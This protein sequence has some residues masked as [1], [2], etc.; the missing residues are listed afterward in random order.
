MLYGGC[1]TKKALMNFWV[2]TKQVIFLQINPALLLTLVFLYLF[3]S[4]IAAQS[5]REKNRLKEPGTIIIGDDI[6][7]PP[8]SFVNAQGEPAG[9]N[10][11]IARAV[12]KEMGLNVVIVQDRWELIREALENGEIDAISGLFYTPQRAEIYGFSSRHSV[13][14]G[15]IFINKK[16]S[17]GAL[18]N[19]KGKEVVAQTADVYAEYLLQL[20]LDIKIIEVGTVKEALMLVDKGIYDYAVVLK[21]PGLYSISEN[22]LQHVKPAGI[23][24]LPKD[25]CMAVKKENEDLLYT[26]NLG[27]HILKA[28]EQYKAIHDKWLGVYEQKSFKD[29]LKENNWILILVG[30]IILSLVSISVMLK[31]LVSKRTR[32]LQQVNLNLQ[33]SN[34]EIGLKNLQLAESQSE[35]E[36]QLEKIQKQGDIIRFKQNFLANMSHEI[37]T[38]LTG[39]IGI[40]DILEKT[41]LSTEQADYI[42]MLRLSGENLREIINQVLDYSKIEAGKLKLKKTDFELTELEKH[43]Y[44]IFQSIAKDSISFESTIDPSIPAR[45][46]ADKNRLMQIISNLISNAIKFTAQGKIRFSAQNQTQSTNPDE[47][48]IKISISDT[49][50]GIEERKLKELFKPFAQ[51]HQSDYREYEGTG[52]GLSICSELVHIHGGEIGVDSKYGSGSTFWFTF[53]TEMAPAS[54]PVSQQINNQQLEKLKNLRILLVEDKI[55]NQKVMKLLL[56]SFGHTLELAE[57]GAIALERYQPGKFDMILMDIQ[58]PVMD[59]ITATRKLREMHPEMPPIIG[60]SANAFEG[61]REKYMDMGLDEYLTKPLKKEDFAEVINRI[62][63]AFLPS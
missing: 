53:K 26:L 8:Y 63:P 52:L 9:F 15:D 46:I 30:S 57:N 22:N 20:D 60:L 19:L 2:N 58:M 43:A 38:P 27:L 4:A 41:K 31:F 17:L 59:G 3:P 39:V 1:K 40:I 13:S 50:L 55:I 47:I 44:T 29:F 36:L 62:M 7:Y 45:I 14:N 35:L 54:Q 33:R 28:S 42:S 11:D 16:N 51:I 18:K 61:D 6:N 34:E 12:A 48:V 32:E 10:I 56:C 21:L 25:Y 5:I 23:N 37:R 24:F 49:G